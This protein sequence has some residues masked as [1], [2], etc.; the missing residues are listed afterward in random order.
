MDKNYALEAYDYTLPEELIAQNPVEP[1]DESR[2]MVVD[3]AD[4]GTWHPG[5]FRQIA[6]LLEPGDCLV[7]N[8]TR[9][10]PARILGKRA[11]GGKVELFL[12]HYPHQDRDDPSRATCT[13]LT[14][15]SKSLKPGEIISADHRLDV[16]FVRRRRDGSAEVSLHYSG[17]LESVLNRAGQTPLPPYIRRAEPES[18]DAERYQ[19]VYATR[20]GSVAAPTA[21]LH[22][23]D[24]ILRKLTSRGIIRCEVTLHVGYGTFAPVRV[25]D[26]R[27]H[28]IHSEF[29]TVSRETC[30]IIN[31]ARKRGGRVIAV[32]TTSV[33]AIEW[34]AGTSGEP[35]PASGECGLYITPGYRFRAVDAIITNFHL[36]RSSLLILVSAFAGRENILNAYNEA[37]ERGYRFYSYGDAMF[38]R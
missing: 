27:Q 3:R 36:P 20:T 12:L 33:R 17:T 7:I 16:E 30:D 1:R 6:N 13:A 31:S 34:C 5:N 2:L 23:T 19:T 25:S 26:I 24:E 22:F 29:V 10:F 38:I 21:G 9:V 35:E 32:G 28:S 11:S 8:N 4:G 37:V 18:R 14:R 15:S